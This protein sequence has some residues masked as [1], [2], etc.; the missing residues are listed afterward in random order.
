MSQEL[1]AEAERNDTS[2]S[3]ST[4]SFH[5]VMILATDPEVPGSIFG[6]TRFS[7]K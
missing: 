4:E 1:L 5:F 3:N 2:G 7:E 6:A